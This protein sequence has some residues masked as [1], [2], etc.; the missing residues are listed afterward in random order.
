[1]VDKWLDKAVGRILAAPEKQ[2]RGARTLKIF[3]SDN[4][5]TANVPQRRMRPPERIGNRAWL[6]VMALIS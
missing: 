4:G 5:G 2:K 6:L 3:I 1:V